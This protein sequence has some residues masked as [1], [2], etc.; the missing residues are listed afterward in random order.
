[1][2]ILS[3]IK[4]VVTGIVSKV[5]G[6]KTYYTAVKTTSSKL[7]GAS[8]TE[9]PT[10]K[11]P[12]TRTYRGG[13]GG[14]SY[15]DPVSGKGYEVSPI[16][17]QKE[18]TIPKPTPP[19]ISISRTT[20]AELRKVTGAKTFEEKTRISREIVEQRKGVA[21]QRRIEEERK[22]I[23]ASGGTTTTKTYKGV[24]GKEEHTIIKG[25][26]GTRILTI[27][28]LETGEVKTRT[29]GKVSGGSVRQT[30]G[31]FFKDVV[32]DKVSVKETPPSS[33]SVSVL[34]SSSLFFT[35]SDAKAQLEKVYERVRGSSSKK[36]TIGGIV[37]GAGAF[38]VWTEKQFDKLDELP[39]I[40]RIQES[41]VITKIKAFGE[42]AGVFLESGRTTE[43]EQGWLSPSGVKRGFDIAAGVTVKAGEVAGETTKP[44]LIK[45][46]VSEESWLFKEA[47]IKTS[48]ARDIISTAYM[49]TAFSSSM[50]T[51]TAQI[52]QSQY[53]D[54]V[55]EVVYKGQKVRILRSDLK[56]FLSSPEK[57]G[58]TY[59]FDVSYSVKAERV[60]E[61]LRN[62]KD[63]KDPTAVKRILEVAR[64][65]YG[66]TFVRD[67][68]SQEGISVGVGSMP[69]TTQTLGGVITGTQP[70]TM[71]QIGLVGSAVS[72]GSRFDVFGQTQSPVQEAWTDTK[73]DQRQIQL[74]KQD[75][76]QDILLKS[77]LVL[78]QKQD[79]KQDQR[80]IQIQKQD[81]KQIQLLKQDTK[82]D[83]M[84]KSLLVSLQSPKQLLKQ[85]QVTREMLSPIRPVP[86]KP[87]PTTLGGALSRVK[88]VIA[89]DEGIFEIFTTKAGKDISI[90]KAG[91]QEE[92]ESLLKE[93]L[94]SSL[95]AGGFLTKSGK[96][97]RAT[98]LKTFG[99]GEFRLSKV[100]PFKIIEKKAKRLRKKTT[101]R[102]I[103]FFR[104]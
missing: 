94:V 27:K 64:E 9:T 48:T 6:A 51:G 17:I 16:G 70:A 104:N 21:E 57:V 41:K 22:R 73:Q 7:P 1:M 60:K 38:A 3:S 15:V 85:P 99:G 24:G 91:T 36:A 96:K 2:G 5:P 65:S 102:Q 87:V 77:A 92:A 79:T 33:T 71:E 8:T 26:G 93:R 42:K 62:L 12:T 74:L 45:A 90:G 100:S 34:R 39:I 20:Q 54:D 10:T 103:Q 28:D 19:P 68:I 30:G 97:V 84:L 44:I 69:A 98:E 82:Q 35:P 18:V 55:V 4:K 46:G 47:P 11:T 40:K 101:G 86:T 23:I 76:K 61:L 80:Q 14:Y 52:L 88:K 32:P 83:S 63:Q 59:K 25:V 89:K 49:F 56:D 37:A 29:Y 95:R 58:K 75:T 78:R 72:S 43:A 50:K 53:A 13:G 31:I 81:T 66:D 67:F